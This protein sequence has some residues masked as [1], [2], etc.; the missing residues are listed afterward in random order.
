MASSGARYSGVW[1]RRSRYPSCATPSNCFR[2]PE[3]V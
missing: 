2:R 3:R 1:P